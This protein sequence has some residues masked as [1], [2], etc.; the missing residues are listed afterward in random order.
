M[1]KTACSKFAAYLR[2]SPIQGIGLLLVIA[3]IIMMLSSLG[4]ILYAHF[5]KINEVNDY[6][7]TIAEIKAGNLE[8]EAF[9]GAPEAEGDEAEAEEDE[10][11]PG[12]KI[13]VL[14]IPSIDCCEVI[15]E[16]TGSSSLRKSLGH[17]TDTAYPGEDGNCVIAG[18]RNYNFGLYFNRLNEVEIGDEISIVTPEGG[19]MYKVYSITTVLPEDTY[20]TEDEGKEEITLITCTPI[21]IASHRLIVKAERIN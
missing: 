16:G 4:M 7:E 20:V 6:L 18:H 15:V 17:M 12:T 21:Y 5:A 1:I 14:S 9:T 11:I 2:K 8:P 10:E 3:G 19:Y 13:G